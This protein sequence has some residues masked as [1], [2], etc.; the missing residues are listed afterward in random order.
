MCVP[1]PTAVNLL[2]WNTEPLA[3]EGTFLVAGVVFSLES[4][5]AIPREV[6]RAWDAPGTSPGPPA[7]PDLVW[8]SV[9]KFH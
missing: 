2:P 5:R 3:L 1:V 7:H 9:P 4:G 6:L 8:A